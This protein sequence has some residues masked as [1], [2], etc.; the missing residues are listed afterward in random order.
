MDL[1]LK[2]KVAMVTGGSRGLGRAMA[3]ALAAEGMSVSICARDTGAVGEVSA[4]LSRIGG[5]ARRQSRGRI[6]GRRHERLRDGKMG[7]CRG[8]RMRTNRR[9]GQ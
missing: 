5:R 6:R 3:E 4:A 8:A 9:A 2:G 1:E 7:R